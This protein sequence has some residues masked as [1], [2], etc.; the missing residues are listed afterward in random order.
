MLGI[1]PIKIVSPLTRE[2]GKV[3]KVNMMR[4]M[5]LFIFTTQKNLNYFLRRSISPET[6]A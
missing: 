1:I 3:K 4:K 5:Q 6:S 2:T